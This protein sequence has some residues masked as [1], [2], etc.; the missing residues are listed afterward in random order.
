MRPWS[1]L[2]CSGAVYISATQSVG[3]TFSRAAALEMSRRIDQVSDYVPRTLLLD[4]LSPKLKEPVLSVALLDQ[5]C[6]APG[7]DFIVAADRLPRPHLAQM[8]NLPAHSQYLYACRPESA[9]AL[10]TTNT[11]SHR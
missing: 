1:G 8:R 2:R 11:V 5:L 7:L 9:R 4:W 3:V 10:A 6:A